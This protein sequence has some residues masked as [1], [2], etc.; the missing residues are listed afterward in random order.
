ML[1]HLILLTVTKGFSRSLT[2]RA[3]DDHLEDIWPLLGATPKPCCNPFAT[4][5]KITKYLN[6]TVI[7][8]KKYH[9]NHYHDF[10]FIGIELK[11]IMHNIKTPLYKR[12]IK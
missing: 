2:P 9:K 7:V 3:I 8:K 6:T 11:I 4:N 1:P 5:L 12:N 10:K